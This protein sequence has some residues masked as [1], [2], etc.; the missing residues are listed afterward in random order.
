MCVHNA[1]WEYVRDVSL[2][3][4]GTPKSWKVCISESFTWRWDSFP[5]IEYPCPVLEWGF[6]SC[7][8][9]SSFVPCGCCIWK[10]CSFLK[11][12]EREVDPGERGGGKLW[13]VNKRQ[14]VV[15]MYY[16]REESLWDFLQRTGWVCH[17]AE[18]RDLVKNMDLVKPWSHHDLAK[19]TSGYRNFKVHLWN[20]R[21]R[22]QALGNS[23][24]YC[25]L[26]R[27]GYLATL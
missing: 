4:S 7:L 16:M 17:L 5:P 12:S 9:V 10:A 8:I 6:L 18:I 23:V 20:H 24:Y 3:F 13:E 14:T 26:H 11:E 19:L 25:C 22:G 2:V 1:L 21:G 27:K 15:R